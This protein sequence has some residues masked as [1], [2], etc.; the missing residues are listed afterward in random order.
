MLTKDSFRRHFTFMCAFSLLK[1]SVVLCNGLFQS[2]LRGVKMIVSLKFQQQE[3]LKCAAVRKRLCLSCSSRLLLI[4][5]GR[6][7]ERA[8]G[9]C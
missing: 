1:C 6:F 5:K 7:R 4:I 2:S 8:A 3:K 9:L